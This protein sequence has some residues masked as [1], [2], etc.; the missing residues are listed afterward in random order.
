MSTLAT[1]EGN[2][3]SIL[4]ELTANFF[5]TAEIYRGISEAYKYYALIMLTKGEGYFETTD[6][7]GFTA[8]TETVSLSSL[9]P[10]FFS[11]SQLYRRTSYG[12]EPLYPSEERFEANFTNGTGTGNTYLPKY[13]LRGSNLIL[14]P[15]P[16]ATEAAS[17][18]TGL[19]L[20]YNYIPTF[21]ASD[22]ASSFSFDANFPTIFEPMIEIWSAIYCME[23]KDGMGGI[24]DI[25]THRNRLEKF[26]SAFMDSLQRDETPQKVQY[27]GQNYG[28]IY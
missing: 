19:K 11:V 2:V 28:V 9:N 4:Q 18:T 22:S 8:A 6:N 1:L 7:L 14:Q 26:E 21:P 23:N 3:R 5:T 10:A 13:K 27:V 20:D 25:S 24:S 17:S 15:A 12:L 16:L